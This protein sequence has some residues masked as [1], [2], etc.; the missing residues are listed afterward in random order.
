LK[1]ETLAV[2]E[3]HAAFDLTVLDG[4][5]HPHVTHVGVDLC[6]LRA[7]Y[8]ADVLGVKQKDLDLDPDGERTRR[9]DIAAGRELWAAVEAWPW[10]LIDEWPCRWWDHRMVVR[11]WDAWRSGRYDGQWLGFA[12][13]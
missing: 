11:A 1:L 10:A 13:R 3:S 8:D 5:G 9:R 4:A 6:R 2:L 7:A 12:P